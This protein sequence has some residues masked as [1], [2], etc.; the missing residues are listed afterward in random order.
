MRRLFHCC[1]EGGGKRS[2]SANGNAEPHN[3]AAMWEMKDLFSEPGSDFV[4]LEL[5]QV[6]SRWHKVDPKAAEDAF[7]RQQV[8]SGVFSDQARSIISGV[9]DVQTG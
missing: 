6:L 5:V 8:F 7:S 9:R 4:Q 3:Y 2:R 1:G